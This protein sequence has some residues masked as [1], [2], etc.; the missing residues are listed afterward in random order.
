MPSLESEDV[1]VDQLT[2]SRMTFLLLDSYYNSPGDDEF[3]EKVE[4]FV[5]RSSTSTTPLVERP[6]DAIWTTAILKSGQI[7][8]L[9]LY[10]IPY[11]DPNE[12]RKDRLFSSSDNKDGNMPVSTQAAI[13]V[14]V[15]RGMSHD[16]IPFEVP[17][18]FG[19]PSVVD[20]SPATH[21]N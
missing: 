9:D 5:E 8:R 13:H 12:F 11:E 17:V 20:M 21:A 6:E 2:M 1:T 15:I 3:V 18:W 4:K 7:K 19:T 14:G 16:S 10:E